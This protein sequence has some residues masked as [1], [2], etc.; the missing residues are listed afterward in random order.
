MVPKAREKTSIFRVFV[1]LNWLALVALPASAAAAEAWVIVDTEARTLTVLSGADVL[2]KYSNVSL[3]RGGVGVTRRQGDGKT[4]VGIFHIA[5]VNRNSRFRLFF[6]LDFPNLDHAHR[7]FTARLIDS[8][9][10]NAIKTAFQR[11]ETPP[12]DT[13]L[14]GFIGIH[15][16]GDGSNRIHDQFNWTDGCVAV[17]NDQIDELD[18]W[19]SVGTKVVIY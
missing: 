1:V 5:W 4:P 15:G 2:A 19:L 11:Q 14:G 8:N 18:R 7:A 6:G 3:G 12:Q 16:V 10:F 17:T 13:P 9:E